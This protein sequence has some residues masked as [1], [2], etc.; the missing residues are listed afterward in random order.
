MIGPLRLGPLRAG[1][2]NFTAPMP[3]TP[4][5]YIAMIVWRGHGTYMAS[6]GTRYLRVE[7]TLMRVGKPTR[8][9]TW[10]PP[11]SVRQRQF[12]RRMAAAKK[13]A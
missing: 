12:E 6:C 7:T 10:F 2:F 4:P 8:R 9:K 5:V 3:D 11:A 1:A 13:R